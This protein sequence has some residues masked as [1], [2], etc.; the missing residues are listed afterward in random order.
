M[1]NEAGGTVPGAIRFGNEGR[2]EM[3]D[4]AEWTPLQRLSDADLPPVM[5]N[6]SLAPSPD[7]GDAGNSGEADGPSDPDDAALA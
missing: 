5:R 4:G 3:F 2:L 6:I 7:P 1:S